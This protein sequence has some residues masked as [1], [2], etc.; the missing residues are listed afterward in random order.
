MAAI[1]LLRDTRRLQLVDCGATGMSCLARCVSVALCGNA[2][3][4]VSLRRV[5]A[6]S[7]IAEACELSRHIRPVASDPSSTAAVSEPDRVAEYFR[8]LEDEREGFNDLRSAQTWNT[9][10]GAPVI[11]ALSEAFQVPIAYA[12][13]NRSASL[14]WEEYRPQKC[15]ATQEA[16]HLVFSTDHWQLA[17]P[18]DKWQPLYA[19]DEN[20]ITLLQSLLDDLKTKARSSPYSI[21]CEKFA[22]LSAFWD[23]SAAGPLHNTT[24]P[25]SSHNATASESE[26]LSQFL[27]PPLP[28]GKRNRDSISTT[29]PR[30][31]ARGAAAAATT[32]RITSLHTLLADDDAR[33][34]QWLSRTPQALELYETR[35]KV[36]CAACLAPVAARDFNVTQHIKKVHDGKFPTGRQGTLVASAQGT[37]RKEAMDIA[38]AKLFAMGLSVTA[39]A[40]IG[41]DVLPLLLVAQSLPSART[42]LRK[43]ATGILPAQ[44]R[45]LQAYLTR[46]LADI[47]IVLVVDGSSTDYS[48][49]AKIAHVLADS[50]L[51]PAPALL[52][53]S[54]VKSES[55]N[56][57]YYADLLKDTMRTYAIDKSNVVGVATDNTNVMPA[58]VKKAGLQH[59]PCVAHVINLAVKAITQAFDVE[60][61]L[62]FRKWLANSPA[63][64]AALHAQGLHPRAL[65]TPEHRFVYTV[66]ALRELLAGW[67]G[68]LKFAETFEKVRQKNSDPKQAESGEESESADTAASESTHSSMGESDGN[69]STASAEDI[70]ALAKQQADESTLTSMLRKLRSRKYRFYATLA[71]ALIEHAESLTS[72]AESDARHDVRRFWEGWKKWE[73]RRQSAHGGPDGAAVDG[74]AF[75]FVT[76]RASHLQ[77]SRKEI[78]ELAPL[79]Q[80][81][82]EQADDK[83]IA[84]MWSSEKVTS[85]V[86]R[87]TRTDVVQDIVAPFR[88]RMAWDVETIAE[89]K[90]GDARYLRDMFGRAV[91]SDDMEEY[92]DL[93]QRIRRRDCPDYNSATPWTFWQ[94][95]R[96]SLP[97]VALAALQALSIPL[98]STA[99]ERSFSVL[100]NREI[101]NRLHAN[102]AYVDMMLML[103]GNRQHYTNMI[104]PRVRALIA[105]TADMGLS[106]HDGDPFPAAGEVAD[107]D[108]RGMHS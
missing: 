95:L 58:A 38:C 85:K 80:Y 6:T 65:K 20:F 42:L 32:T 88:R 16:V 82:L 81:A 93:L 33:S 9:F 59:I 103:A 53:V 61:V 28:G 37:P 47:P 102:E 34:E 100:S 45:S 94:R 1:V 41:S 74:G 46:I 7:M 106:A 10:M 107:L 14:Y 2:E 68:Y 43:D 101:D 69:E 13:V 89:L 84:H 79:V 40:N 72:L 97:R 12:Q 73:S 21:V 108:P 99:A 62:G 11:H 3:H 64:V 48:G 70:V 49:G 50:S 4:A 104:A 71:L 26:F 15:S 24:Q 98:S 19:D 44:V 5:A 51:L 77:P 87:K 83:I 75:V 31:R 22:A 63:R 56:A 23:T 60:D 76:T 57:L 91:D 105:P 39:I 25:E 54:I 36:V 8:I 67:D 66:P 96:G 55:M 52:T 27:S 30:K 86:G 90:S 18:V 78:E 35:G 92:T 29:T 17:K